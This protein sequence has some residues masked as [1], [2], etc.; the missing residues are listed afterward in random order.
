MKIFAYL[1][2]LSS[3]SGKTMQNGHNMVVGDVS[4]LGLCVGDAHHNFILASSRENLSSAFPTKRDSN[5]PAQLPRL[6]R[7]LKFLL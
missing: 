6:A 1:N 3:E 2:H 4:K 7:K 5:Q